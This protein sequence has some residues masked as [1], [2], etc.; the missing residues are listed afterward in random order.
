[1]KA[2]IFKAEEL[3]ATN[4]YCKQQ[5]EKAFNELANKIDELIFNICYESL[6]LGE[7]MIR[8]IG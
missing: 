6:N 4:E 7:Y 1:M 3:A 8:I 2:K 5:A